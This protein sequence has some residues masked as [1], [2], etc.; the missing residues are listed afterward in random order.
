MDRS[1]VVRI[2]ILAGVV[3]TTLVAVARGID[4][5]DIAPMIVVTLL[6]ILQRGFVALRRRRR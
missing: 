4:L 3:I 2:V 1:D 5:R 6:A